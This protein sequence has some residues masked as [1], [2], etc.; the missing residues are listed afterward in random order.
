MGGLQITL[1]VIF[2]ASFA[3]LRPDDALAAP[4]IS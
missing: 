3:D 1:I 2:M 4:D